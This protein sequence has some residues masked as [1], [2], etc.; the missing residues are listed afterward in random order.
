M[1]LDMV[2][3][4]GDG[5]ADRFAYR[6]WSQRMLAGDPAFAGGEPAM[7]IELRQPDERKRIATDAGVL[8]PLI[9]GNWA[10]TMPVII[11]TS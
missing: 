4:A 3:E 9:V 1:S 11:T 10:G 5:D 7:P 2:L 8:G 6:L